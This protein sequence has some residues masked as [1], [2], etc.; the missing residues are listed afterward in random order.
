MSVML[1]LLWIVQGVLGILYIGMDKGK[2][3][4]IGYSRDELWTL[5][6]PLQKEAKDV[7]VSNHVKQLIM[8]YGIR[9]IPRPYRRSRAG[10]KLLQRIRKIASIANNVH[11]SESS[12]SRTKL[13]KR[14]LVP[15]VPPLIKEKKEKKY[16]DR[17]YLALANVRSILGK[18]DE[19]QMEVHR[20]KL[21]LLVI[22]ESWLTKDDHVTS[23]VPPDGFDIVSIPRNNGCRGGG[24][25]LLYKTSSV[26]MLS[27]KSYDWSSCEMADFHIKIGNKEIILCAVYRPPQLNVME[28]LQDFT[29]YWENTITSTCERIFIGDFNIRVDKDG[30]PNTVMFKDCLESLNLT[31]KVDFLTH[32]LGHTLDIVILDN[33][34]SLIPIVNQGCF[35][36]DHSLIYME[37]MVG[38][39]LVEP[40]AKMCRRLSKVDHGVLGIKLGELVDRIISN[41]DGKDVSLLAHEYEV[42]IKGVLDE[43]SPMV[44]VKQKSKTPFPWMTEDVKREVALRR[45]KE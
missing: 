44:K 30:D 24:I 6:P 14:C 13:E 29:S 27:T 3:L 43:I 35:I 16:N 17:I 5:K 31:C 15:L 12:R 22:T 42:E 20:H 19:V 34:S 39:E 36:S 41:A 1:H 11:Y 26:K 45:S 18:I 21:D 9:R 10:V 4:P 32:E 37:L 40:K 33:T 38:R 2:N 23:N 7:S 25:S 28:F 8:E